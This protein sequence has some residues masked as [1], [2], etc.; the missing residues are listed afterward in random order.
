M[1]FTLEELTRG[2]LR[3]LAHLHSS[4]VLGRGFA[5]TKELAQI[6]D[7]PLELVAACCRRLV[8]LGQLTVAGDRGGDEQLV[9][10]TAAGL[11][12]AE[13]AVRP[14]A[15]PANV[16]QNFHGSVGIVA[17]QVGSG[18]TMTPQQRSGPT[19]DDVTALIAQL[20]AAL[21]T[22]PAED[23]KEAEGAADNLEEG[24]KTGRMAQVNRAMLNL[25]QLGTSSATVV[26]A[27]KALGKAFGL[28]VP[29]DA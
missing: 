29:E 4:H 13:D 7:E 12:A 6:L 21:P 22:L 28:P 27:L 16:T 18:N 20:R 24:A 10:I 26:T 5:D 3:I 19:L 8:T 11:R 23:R 25:G 15:P 9:Q 2:S 14:P 1:A 17:T